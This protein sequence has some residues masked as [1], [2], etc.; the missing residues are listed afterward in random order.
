ME[1][2][3]QKPSVTVDI[4]VFS[5]QNQELK[6]LLVKRGIPPFQGTW[7]I[8]GGFVRLN[9]SLEEAAKR[10][11]EE[12]TGVKEVYLEQLYTFGDVNRD[13][14]GRTITVAYFALIDS[15]KAKQKLKAT[16]DAS[17]AE[18]FSISALP[19]LAF[20]HD[21]ILKYALKRLRWKFEYTTIVFSMLPKKFTLT[22]LQKNYEI[23]FNKKFDKRN[24]RKKILS[25]NLVEKTR[26]IQKDVSHRP[27]KLYS[28]KKR[29]GEIVEILQPGS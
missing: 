21:K 2:E 10:E 16:T 15:E 18:W 28:F 13:P 7:A 9:E 8:P 6:V 3:Y 26:E 14:R 27:P 1:K 5:I 20:D 4:I 17:E 22:Q 12:E 24:F 11:L 19:H 29:I 25:L 23:V